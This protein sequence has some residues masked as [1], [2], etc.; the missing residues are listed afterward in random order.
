[1]TAG[2]LLEDAQLRLARASLELI[3][4]AG[5]TTDPVEFARLRGKVE[6]VKLAADY[7]RVYE[8]P[9]WPRK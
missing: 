8:E 2:E 4:L 5:T 3:R 9:S 7:L 1:V 6:G